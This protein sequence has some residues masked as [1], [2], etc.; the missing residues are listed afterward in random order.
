[1]VKTYRMMRHFTWWEV[2]LSTLST[3]IGNS[4]PCPISKIS[5]IFNHKIHRLKIKIGQSISVNKKRVNLYKKSTGDEASTMMG[6]KY[7]WLWQFEGDKDSMETI[8]SRA[9][10]D[11]LIHSGAHISFRLAID[12]DQKK[13]DNLELCLITSHQ[14]QNDQHIT[15]YEFEA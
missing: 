11:S 15:S 12:N 13:K 7:S 10:H 9:S 6:S 5:R 2:W 8:I 3:N 14:N 1:M 4:M